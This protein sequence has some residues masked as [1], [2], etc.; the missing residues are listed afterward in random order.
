ML[1]ILV[2]YLFLN[3]IWVKVSGHSIYPPMPWDNV[4]QLFYIPLGFLAAF[5][6]VEVSLYY[7]T[8]KKLSCHAE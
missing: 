2:V 3:I 4:A 1:L 5:S 7:L 6:A 8:R